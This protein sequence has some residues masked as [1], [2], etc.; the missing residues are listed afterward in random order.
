MA[1]TT[2]IQKRSGLPLWLKSLYGTCELGIAGF[3]TLRQIF[4][5]IFVTDVVGL[6]P[7]LA[8]IAV[9]VG[10]VWDAINDPLVGTL[11]DRINT[12]WASVAH[13]WPCSL[14]PLAWLF[15]LC[16]GL[17]LSSSRDG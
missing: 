13:S 8:S 6:A 11:S 15:W 4:Y 1:T 16:G 10:V 12:R 17:R 2:S 3:N 14:Y 9:V 7:G 5:A